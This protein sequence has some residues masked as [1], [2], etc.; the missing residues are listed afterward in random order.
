MSKPFVFVVVGTDSSKKQELVNHLTNEFKDLLYVDVPNPPE[1]ALGSLADYRMEIFHGLTRYITY[2]RYYKN[3]QDIVVSRSLLDSIVWYTVNAQRRIDNKVIDPN[4]KEDKKYLAAALA[5][6]LIVLDSFYADHIFVLKDIRNNEDKIFY[7]EMRDLLAL[8]DI[9]QT[10][11]DSAM[12]QKQREEN[13]AKII[14]GYY[15]KR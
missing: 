10:F 15:D 4:S 5:F 7:N 8:F 2:G 13:S 14:Q 6:Y 9:E 12:S 1:Y 11:F 3:D